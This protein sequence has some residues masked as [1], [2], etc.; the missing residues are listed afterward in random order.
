MFS[1]D[2]ETLAAG[3]EELARLLADDRRKAALWQAAAVLR[4]CP[5]PVASRIDRDG[6]EG[7]H[8]LGIGYELAGAITDWVRSGQLRWREQLLA[9]RRRELLRV[10]GLN[11]RLADALYDV[12]GIVDVEGL[13]RA[14]REGQLLRVCG[15]GPKR[16]QQ[17]TAQ[18][19]GARAAG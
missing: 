14:A 16:V 1:P 5:E 15:F 18:L 13:A 17:L 4:R 3:L 9:E 6:L 12:L 8:A 19:C 11:R 2:N 7:V 10:S